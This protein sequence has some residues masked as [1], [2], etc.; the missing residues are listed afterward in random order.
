MIGEY[1]LHFWKKHRFCKQFSLH[2]Y[3]KVRECSNMNTYQYIQMNTAVILHRWT[4]DPDRRLSICAMPLLLVF[5]PFLKILFWSTAY[6]DML[7]VKH[8]CVF[9][10]LSHWSVQAYCFLKILRAS[11]FIFIFLFDTCIVGFSKQE[12][13]SY[14]SV[15]LF[16]FLFCVSVGDVCFLIILNTILSRFSDSTVTTANAFII[17]L[18][19]TN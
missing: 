3:F 2:L 16:W 5:R 6:K 15:L 14:W 7:W 19:F 4:P 1:F 8:L 18:G 17:I 12:C 10:C 9:C 11:V 13:H